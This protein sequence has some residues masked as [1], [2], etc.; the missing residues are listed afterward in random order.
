M[1][2]SKRKNHS[3]K[4]GTSLRGSL[5][6]REMRGEEGVAVRW[7]DEKGAAVVAVAILAFACKYLLMRHWNAKANLNRF[8]FFDATRGGN[9]ENMSE[10]E[11]AMSGGGFFAPSAPPAVPPSV[12][13]EA[14]RE[15]WVR[16]ITPKDA[17]ARSLMAQMMSRV[18]KNPKVNFIL[19]VVRPMSLSFSPPF[20]LITPNIT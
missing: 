16:L 1:G 2:G 8:G 9:R 19:S 3:S 6:R 5:R 17:E 7:F 13:L 12:A 15:N 4:R 10:R 18:A 20:L 11:Y 14:I